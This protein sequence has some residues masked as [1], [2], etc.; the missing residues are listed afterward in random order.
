M[1]ERS[2]TSRDRRA[3]RGGNTGRTQAQSAGPAHERPAPYEQGTTGRLPRSDLAHPPAG[4][5]TAGRAP[6]AKHG[7][8]IRQDSC[9]TRRGHPPHGPPGP[10]PTRHKAPHPGSLGRPS[11]GSQP[12]PAQPA[13][14]P[15]LAWVK[16]TSP[17][18]YVRPRPALLWKHPPT[19][20]QALSRHGG[21]SSLSHRQTA[22]AIARP[23]Q[24]AALG[25]P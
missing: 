1:P 16:G 4:K 15:G 22:P 7:K 21:E 5:S 18:E 24:P 13:R 11:H 6:G 23:L 2:G 19:G 9:N 10:S 8:Q 17:T 25:L 12:C 20:S 14:T 3:R